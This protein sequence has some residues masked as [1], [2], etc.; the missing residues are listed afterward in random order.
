[1]METPEDYICDECDSEEGA[2]EICECGIVCCSDCSRNDDDGN[3]LCP[4]CF[5]DLMCE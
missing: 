5:E 3:T 2:M 1:M 4:E